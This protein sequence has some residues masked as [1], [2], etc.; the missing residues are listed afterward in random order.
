MSQATN[1]VFA[2]PVNLDPAV[3]ENRTF[4]LKRIKDGEATWSQRVA[5]VPAADPSLT[6]KSSV[7]GTGVRRATALLTLPDYETQ[8][9]QTLGNKVPYITVQ[10]TVVSG[11]DV[12]DILRF[13]AQ[14]LVHQ[15]MYN[16]SFNDMLLGTDDPV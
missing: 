15:M 2:V 16:A 1:L 5:L 14:H 12:R 13:R 4:A 3:T 6:F 9:L 7:S 10:V 11:G 8:T